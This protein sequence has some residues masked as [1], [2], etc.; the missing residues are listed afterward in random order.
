MTS[1]SAAVKDIRLS[2][3]APSVVPRAFTSTELHTLGVIADVLIPASASDPAPTSEPGY[4]QSLVVA[5]NARADAFDAIVAVLDELVGADAETTEQH[6]RAL[7]ETDHAVF[8]P[9]SSVIA[10]AWL[11]LPAVRDRIGYP[12]QGRHQAP[13]EQIADELSTGI[14]DPVIERGSIY[15][16]APEHAGSEPKKER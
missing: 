9:L 4:E 15:T 14:L 10:G 7:A 16:P 6:L 8:Q 3:P 12:G 2:V 11:L 1:N 13:L 5:A